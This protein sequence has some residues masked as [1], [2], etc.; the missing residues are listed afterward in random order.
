[1]TCDATVE[2]AERASRG[3]AIIM[4]IAAAVLLISAAIQY[5]DPHYVEPGIRSGSWIVVVGLWMFI[6]AR[7]GG[8]RMSGR[9]RE[10]LNDEL[11]LRNRS[12]AIAAGFYV[13]LGAALLLY[14]AAWRV[15]IAAGDA[16][17]LISAAG[18][19]TALFV[20]AWLEWN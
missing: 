18:L 17:K 4:A 7:G 8:L 19:A 2:S 1:M 20:Y 11:S 10:L 14:L 3:R 6:L 13:A 5:G 15:E 12:R 16:I 9:M